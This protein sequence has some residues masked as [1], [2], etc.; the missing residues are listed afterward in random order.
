MGRGQF[1]SY[2]SA[3]SHAT[4]TVDAAVVNLVS[5]CDVAFITYLDSI[6]YNSTGT[7]V[8]V[9]V[10]FHFCSM[11]EA[12]QLM[13]NSTRTIHHPPCIHTGVFR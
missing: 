11:I 1:G 2:L 7:V 9:V 8:P 5:L 3:G 6:P 4:K 12:P 13:S 10:L